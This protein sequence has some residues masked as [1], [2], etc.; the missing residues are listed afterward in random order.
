MDFLIKE[1][2]T[3]QREPEKIKTILSHLVQE[4]RQILLDTSTSLEDPTNRGVLLHIF[5][6]MLNHGWGCEKDLVKAKELYEMSASLN[7]TDAMY[8][9]GNLYYG[10]DGEW[11]LQKAKELYKQAATHGHVEAMNTLDFLY[12]QGKIGTKEYKKTSELYEQAVTPNDPIAIFNLARMYENGDKVPLNYRKAIELYERAAQ[13]NHPESM[14]RLAKLYLASKSDANANRILNLYFS[15]F[16]ITRD[17][18]T[19]AYDLILLPNT[20]F[21]TFLLSSFFELRERVE[22][23]NGENDL[24]SS[25]IQ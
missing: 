24:L 14:I 7:N 12:K 23:R 19:I 8:H 5:G 17:V 16:Q 13:M 25:P 4:Q 18:K 11:N 10:I 6:Q 9:L 15:Y 3:H 22:Q 2:L 20:G 1:L 21:L